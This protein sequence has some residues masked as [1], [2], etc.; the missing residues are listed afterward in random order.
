MQN[1]LAKKILDPAQFVTFYGTT[2]PKVG[3]TPEQIETAATKLVERVRDLPIDGFVVYDVQ[4]ETGRTTEPRPFPY[5]ATLDPRV[6]SK[7][8][9]ELSGRPTINYK[10][11]WNTEEA[12]WS[13][14]LDETSRVYGV[15]FLSLVGIPTPVP[16]PNTI[17]VGRAFQMAAAHPA[18]FTLGGVAIAE[19]HSAHDSESRRIQQKVD[20]GCSYFV[21]QGIYQPE[22]TIRLFKDYVADCKQLG[23]APRRIVLTFIP[24]GRE[25]TMTFMK[26]LGVQ[27]TPETEHAILGAASPLAKS[28]EVCRDNLRR[29]LDQDYVN[30]LPIGLNIE[31]IS[32]TKDELAGSVDL[33]YALQEVVREYAR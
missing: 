27:I 11:V 6:Y 2:P 31:S 1:G 29:I 19:R 32:I 28:I 20:A 25:R 15:E 9:R 3:S 22:A 8:L 7:L 23:V 16:L 18:G 26:W 21:T 13:R 4:E 30:V 12:A 14:W 10:C 24:V 5:M 33:F 17:H